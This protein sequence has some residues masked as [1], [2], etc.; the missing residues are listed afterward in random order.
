MSLILR[1]FD[2][3]E[4]AVSRSLKEY[5]KYHVYYNMNNK[6]WIPRAQIRI[7]PKDKETTLEKYQSGIDIEYCKTQNPNQIYVFIDK[8]DAVWDY[9]IHWNLTL[10]CHYR[11]INYIQSILGDRLD[12]DMIIKTNFCIK[13]QK[14]NKENFYPVF[15]EYFMYMLHIDFMA[16][17]TN[18][19]RNIN[20]NTNLMQ[21]NSYWDY[22]VNL[23]NSWVCETTNRAIAAKE[24]SEPTV[25]VLQNENKTEKMD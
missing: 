16:E 20:A 6:K 13:E 22:C 25:E 2:I 5:K 23:Y 21:L 17:Y 7:S 12:Q 19:Y 10:D 15:M 24:P 18:K 4:Y 3:L 11:F 1:I 9:I 14:I 8:N